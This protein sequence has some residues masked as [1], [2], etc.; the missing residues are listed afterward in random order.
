MEVHNPLNNNKEYKILFVCLGNIC[1]SPAAEAVL[2]SKLGKAG[3]TPSKVYVDS[4]GIGSWHE[5]QLPDRRMREHGVLRGY[6]ISSRARQVNETDFGRFDF[7]FAMDDENVAALLRMARNE[8]EREKVMRM[9][10]FITHH[11][12]YTTV[13]DPYYG[14][15][16]AFELALDLIEDAC[17]G[18]MRWLAEKKIV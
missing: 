17:D 2:Q 4:A 16:E 6:D 18:I 5:G 3:I 10:D 12:G 7:I 9:G 8:E 13:P 14:D 11:K 15:G 1:R